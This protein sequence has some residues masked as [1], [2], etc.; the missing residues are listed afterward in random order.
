MKHDKLVTD[1]IIKIIQIRIIIKYIWIKKT[2][3]QRLL[4]KSYARYCDEN[5][6]NR[7][8]NCQT[9]CKMLEI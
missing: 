7:M 5:L 3:I 4:M 6:V 9:L 2:Y 1:K 8:M